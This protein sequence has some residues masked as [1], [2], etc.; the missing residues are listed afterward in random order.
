MVNMC[1]T[2]TG[3]YSSIP[4]VSI[5]RYLVPGVYRYAYIYCEKMKKGVRF[6]VRTCYQYTHI[7]TAVT[8]NT[9]SIGICRYISGMILFTYSLLTVTFNSRYLVKLVYLVLRAVTIY[10]I[11]LCTKDFT[12]KLRSFC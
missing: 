8:T 2:H 9:Y 1:L 11:P 10:S 12:C 4:V 6:S 7:V 3:L 5:T